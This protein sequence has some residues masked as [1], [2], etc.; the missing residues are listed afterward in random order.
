[1]RPPVVVQSVPDA[2]AATSS[3]RPRLG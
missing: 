3:R 1:L 2:P